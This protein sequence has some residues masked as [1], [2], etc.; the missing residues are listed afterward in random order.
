MFKVDFS[1]KEIKFPEFQQEIMQQVFHSWVQVKLRNFIA[2]HRIRPLSIV[3]RLCVIYLF[4]LSLYVSLGHNV[5]VSF[6]LYW[7]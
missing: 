7:Y 6:M 3:S 5:V 1:Q 2:A 4:V